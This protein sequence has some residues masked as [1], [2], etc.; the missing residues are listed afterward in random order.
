MDRPNG[1]AEMETNKEK[2]ENQ[3]EKEKNEKKGKIEKRRE[4]S[5]LL[6]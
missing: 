6:L 1:P 3:K 2:R 5:L 4:N